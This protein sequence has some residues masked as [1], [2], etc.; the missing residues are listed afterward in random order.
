MKKEIWKDIPGYE[1]EY[2]ISNRGRLKSFM[3]N[4]LGEIRSVKNRHGLY[5][6]IPLCVCQKKKTVRIHRLVAEAFIPNP[7]NKPTVNHKDLDKQN[8]YASNLEWATYKENINHAIKRI[9]SMIKGMNNYNQ[10]I[11]PRTIIQLDLYGR[12]IA[13][14]KNSIEAGKATG[15]CYRNILQVASKDEYKPG[16]TRKQAGGF[17]WRYKDEV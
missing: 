10:N 16:L 3:R 1:G 7:E 9:P 13:E 5:Q 12:F 11:R 4:K 17:K 15:V 8:N 2:Q 6:T 14:F